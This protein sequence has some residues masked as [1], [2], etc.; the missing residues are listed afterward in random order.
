MKENK[1][2][3]LHTFLFMLA[4]LLLVAT[5]NISNSLTIQPNK[6]YAENENKSEPVENNSIEFESNIYIDD[7]LALDSIDIENYDS[8]I[9]NNF[10]LASARNSDIKEQKPLI[11]IDSGH[12]AKDPGSIGPAGT[13]EKDITLS[14]ALK[15]GYLLQRKGINVVYTRKDD[16]I[17]WSGQKEELLERAKLS[18]D[19]EAD[20]F[21]SLHA[22]SSKIQS[23]GGIETYYFKSSSK[24]KIFA[25]AVQEE[26]TKAIKLRDRGIKP[27]NYSV[28][29]NVEAPSILIELGYI[30]NEQEEYI[31][32][33]PKYQNQY[34]LSIAKATIN[35]VREKD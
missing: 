32:N 4:L 34:A 5:I 13:M 9:V 24:G 15:L 29:R 16:N 14:V 18:N 31:L 3:F 21:I 30:S 11:V 6:S 1:L 26:L 10:L 33:E 20:L 22:N 12:G 2:K 28:L 8:S 25:A 35:F 23:A 19:V 17:Q 27:E 7:L